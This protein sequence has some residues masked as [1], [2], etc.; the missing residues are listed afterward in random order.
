MFPDSSYSAFASL[1]IPGHT[2]GS[3]SM[4]RL[5]PG[6]TNDWYSHT[7]RREI[8]GLY[9]LFSWINNW[10]TEDHQFLDMFIETRDSLGHVDH[11]ILDLGSSFGASAIGPKALWESYETPSTSDGLGGGSCRLGSRKNPGGEL[12][13]T[14]AFRR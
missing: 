12:I 13:R 3:P 10:D 11:Y 2:L 9:P 7:N 4:D 6:D 5:R 14:R 1:F 8:R